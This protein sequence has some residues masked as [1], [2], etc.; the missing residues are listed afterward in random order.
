MGPDTETVVGGHAGFNKCLTQELD[1]PACRFPQYATSQSYRFLW[2]DLD[3]LDGPE[4]S[5]MPIPE[6]EVQAPD[7]LY[8][9]PPMGNRQVGWLVG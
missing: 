8:V 9:P 6:A 3:D 4:A 7:P 2:P 5:F 1:H